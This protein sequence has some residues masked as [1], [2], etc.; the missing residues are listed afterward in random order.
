MIVS[1]GRSRAGRKTVCT[2]CDK[3]QFF[4]NGKRYAEVFASQE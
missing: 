2:W 1:A 4:P 3:A